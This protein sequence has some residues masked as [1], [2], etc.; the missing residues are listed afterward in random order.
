M[1]W[2]EPAAI[3]VTAALALV[4]WG[5]QQAIA[6]AKDWLL[7]WR[8]DSAVGREVGRILLSDEFLEEGRKA[9]EFLIED[10]AKRL[11][12]WY[13]DT[14]KALGFPPGRLADMIEG[15]VGSKLG[16][17]AVPT[18]LQLPAPP[19]AEVGIAVSAVPTAA[20]GQTVTLP[21]GFIAS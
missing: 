5:G 16:T 21:I 10:G 7:R 19:P 4:G 13:P 20:A 17:T 2:T 11:E 3:L 15:A 1:N 12:G 14:L 6:I 9:L 8:L 18:A